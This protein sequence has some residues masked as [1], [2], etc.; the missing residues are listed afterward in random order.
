MSP[1]GLMG[2]M[3]PIG[4]T[5]RGECPS[6]E[7][8]LVFD[9]RRIACYPSHS[10]DQQRC[11]WESNPLETGLQPVAYPSGSRIMGSIPARS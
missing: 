5:H 8:N 4:P 10:K 2:L 7:S 1:I 3:G 6:Q 11:V 9:L